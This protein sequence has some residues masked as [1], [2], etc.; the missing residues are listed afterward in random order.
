MR[1][2]RR[3]ILALL[4]AV[5]SAAATGSAFADTLVATPQTVS[6]VTGSELIFWLNYSD[7]SN[8]PVSALKFTIVTPPQHGTLQS[9]D[10]R[11]SITTWPLYYFYRATNGF[12]GSDSMTWEVSDGT[13]TSVTAV[14]TF[15]VT[16]NHAPVAQN[17]SAPVVQNTSRKST[18]LPWTH[19][20][21]GQIMT[22][23]LGT[24]PTKGLLEY[25]SGGYTNVPPQTPLSSGTWYYTPNP[26]AIGAD[27]FKW[28]VSDQIATSSVA[29]YT[30]TITTNTPPIALGAKGW[31]CANQQVTVPALFA[32]PDPQSFSLQVL[33]PP[34]HA[35]S[36]TVSGASFLYTPVNGYTGTDTFS[37]AIS[38]GSVTSAPA[39]GSV[40][41]RQ[42]PT[43]RG[44]MVV[45]AV[46]NS[47]LY[48]EISN[49]VSQLCADLQ[50]EG[51]TAKL[52]KLPGTT[53]ATSLWSNLRSEYLAPTQFL[54]G[55]I[56]VGNL[57][58]AYGP[59]S[60][61]T[62][63][64]YWNMLQMGDT[65]YGKFHIWVSRMWA[66]DGAG[67]TLFCG[68]EAGL[69]KRVLRQNH[70]CRTGVSRLPFS[71][72][73][74]EIFSGTN[75]MAGI[76]DTWPE[77][78]YLAPENAFVK[79]GNL[80]DETSHGGPGAYSNMQLMNS[81]MIHNLLAQV[82][83]ALCS[84]CV[85]GAFGGVVN[86]QLLTRGG[87]NGFS[88][89][90]TETTYEGAFE[91]CNYGG[92]SPLRN[93]LA[94]GECW[95]NALVKNYEFNDYYRAVFY[96]D[97]SLPT[98]DVASNVMPVVTAMTASVTN[99]RAPLTVS[100]TAAANDPDGSLASYEWYPDGY[101]YGIAT[102]AVSGATAT[103]ASRTYNL[104]HTYFA[105]VQVMDNYEARAWKEVEIRVAPAT[106]QVLRVNCGYVR[107]YGYANGGYDP[108]YDYTDSQGRLW[109]HD[110]TYA[111]GTWGTDGMN[112]NV[113]P[114]SGAISNTPDDVL[115]RYYTCDYYRTSGFHY[116]I[117][118]AAG[119]YK[120]NLGFC[121][122]VNTS[123]GKR[124]FDVTLNGQPFLKTFDIVA[125]GGLKQ[126]VFVST[127]LTLL[128]GV[129][130]IFVKTSTNSPVGTY[131]SGQAILNCFEIAPSS[132]N[133]DCTLTVATSG[134]GSGTV[135]LDPPGFVYATGTLVQ[136]TAV[137]ATNS[138]F[139]GW[140]G[141]LSGTVNPASL[142]MTTDTLL[143]AS[144]ALK[145]FT[146][147]AAAGGGGVIAPAG[148]IG[149]DY[150]S[151]QA[152]TIAAGDGYE[153][154]DV[155]VDGSSV[156]P[157]A[158][159]NFDNVTSDR[160]IAASFALVTTAPVITSPLTATGAVGEAFGYVITAIHA[161][162]GFTAAGLPPGLSLDPNTGA[163][164]GAPAAAGATDVAI[165][166]TNA[167]GADTR[168]LRLTVACAIAASAGAHGGIAPAGRVLVAGG[169][170]QAFAITPGAWYAI[171]GVLVDGVPAGA[172]AAY[173]FVNATTNHTIAAAFA[174]LLAPRGTPQ[175]WLAQYGWTNDFAAAEL[176]DQDGDG[177]A[178]WREYLA[179][180]EPAD[181]LS[182]PAYNTL[183]YAES[184]EDT[185]GWGGLNT[186][187]SGRMGWSAGTDGVDQSRIVNLAYVYSATNLPLPSATHTNVLRVAT[188]GGTLT[189][190]FG[191]GF[192]MGGALVYMDMM[193]RFDAADQ[194]LADY[195]FADTGIK[196]GVYAST[197][198]QLMVFHGVAAADGML[199]SNTVDATAVFAD[200]TN[201]HR[202]T[203]TI[204]ATAT[205]PANALAMF[206]VKL[207]GAP[208][209]S[210]AAYGNGWKAQFETTGVLPATQSNGTWFRL[211]TTNAET[212]KL[213]AMC[214]AG[215]GYGDDVVV[216]TVDPF[217]GAPGA[218]FMLIVTKSGNGRSS[219]GAAPCVATPVAVGATTQIV[220]TADEWNRISTLAANGAAA[221]SASGA[222]V[223]TQL[224][225]NICADISNAVV[226]AQVTPEQ[227]GYTNA[228]IGWLTNWS[229]AAVRAG[230][231]DGFDL[232]DKYLLGLDPTSSNSYRLKVESLAVSGSN[233]VISVRR[234][235]TGDISPDGM[236]GYLKLQAVD[237]LGG[238]FTNL[239]GTAITGATVFDGAGR[240]AYTNAIEGVRRFYR[241]LIE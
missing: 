94:A 17:G 234:V 181:P 174:P 56:L 38:D 106:G 93:G 97:L 143:T 207:D 100:F 224:L 141:A 140:S 202:L 76:R 77:L 74:Y 233:V 217:A 129:L 121:D 175:W 25:Y 184:F 46:V 230:G 150:G 88:V 102:S 199:L 103:A 228:P 198:N 123:A 188:H 45:L 136:A 195:K 238:S 61:L 34:A 149:I 133:D 122:M 14:C 71:A 237:N 162:A 87:G 164:S 161:P 142:S 42:Q 52:L 96:G 15:D 66:L 187:I 48:P 144:F 58:K 92:A 95:G 152:F 91:I 191:S 3:A 229:E 193:V 28:S 240:R 231:G 11:Y 101:N 107:S 23:T 118:L 40:L 108:D 117:P 146:I 8:R 78:E 80:I 65:G 50:T 20:D 35:A 160:T 213:T 219:L 163:I 180:T 145:S 113:M 16:A 186:N 235:V 1:V 192:E 216:T 115:F 212:K 220:Y 201:W 205:N 157:V 172:V 226:F 68:D 110:Q 134:T 72:Y 89:G 64:A 62:D 99:G 239:D 206:E 178:T 44:G 218:T 98:F 125:A 183:P 214:F 155:L 5:L 196:G 90:A 83:S 105:R 59:S 82:R 166:A 120:L 236:H 137:P 177:V 241:A 84:S 147:R 75:Y 132:L 55:A 211:A 138:L 2:Q 208:A 29:T 85:S 70:D 130:D 170:D 81:Y 54:A 131:G 223:F 6:L 169:A 67:H 179:R 197:N 30:Y 203:L 222:R 22:Y 135:S 227:T 151:S 60:E 126:P 153:V 109:L 200:S 53:A 51:Y 221:P 26:G 31:T 57:P 112:I 119:A 159:Y 12:S 18:I 215:T 27:T 37:W 104:P 47:T 111:T 182:R 194:A 24:A 185:T 19:T 33:S 171:A 204:D 4:A 49:E 127:N 209:A 225:A 7:A 36:F 210:P 173:T 165:A 32:D 73:Y 168:T 69:L 86:N 10:E 41:V 39:T 232:G 128:D 190:S 176:G 148:D 43:D 116:K 158:A 79:G 114:F 156:G 154:A 21:A 139:A 189:N 9:Y 63:C 124:L 167:F 13:L